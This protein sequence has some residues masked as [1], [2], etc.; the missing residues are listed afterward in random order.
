MKEKAFPLKHFTY[1]FIVHGCFAHIHVCVTW[2]L[3]VFGGQKRALDLLELKSQMVVSSR[4]GAGNPSRSCGRAA[5]V[6]NH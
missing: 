4:I 1:L 2:E 6:P 3:G 5:S